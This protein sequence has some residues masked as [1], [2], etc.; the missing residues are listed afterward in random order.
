MITSQS[1]DNRTGCD[2]VIHIPE[3]IADR[4]GYKSAFE[5]FLYFPDKKKSNEVQR[6]FTKGRVP[7]E[8][9][10]NTIEENGNK[11][12]TM[13]KRTRKSNT[14]RRR[15]LTVWDCGIFR[16]KGWN[17]AIKGGDPYP[18]IYGR[19]NLGAHPKNMVLF[20]G[21]PPKTQTIWEVFLSVTAE[22][23]FF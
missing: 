21:E 4:S 12:I 17:F 18:K 8:W 6:F 11:G 9:Q 13:D 14:L 19:Q 5:F 23:F 15:R 2:S 3:V 1:D 16:K 20:F 10:P 22:R 7:E